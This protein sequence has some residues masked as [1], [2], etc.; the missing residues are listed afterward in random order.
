MVQYD[1]V[2]FIRRKP[3]IFSNFDNPNANISP[4]EK[5]F[6]LSL[7]DAHPESGFSKRIFNTGKPN[8]Y[9]DLV[10]GRNSAFSNKAYANKDLINVFRKV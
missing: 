1:L 9:L 3:T 8:Q 10:V 4:I 2:R 5:D 7:I 6:V